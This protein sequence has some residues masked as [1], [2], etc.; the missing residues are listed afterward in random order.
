MVAERY[1]YGRGPGVAPGRA[2]GSTRWQG[3]GACRECGGRGIWAGQAA[4]CW[5]MVIWA[6]AVRVGGTGDRF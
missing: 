3:R 4:I 1:G 5:Q 6:A 2:A